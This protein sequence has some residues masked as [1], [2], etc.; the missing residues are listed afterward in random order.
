MNN[1]QFKIL[2]GNHIGACIDL[3][4]AQPY[5]AINDHNHDIYLP[6]TT[7]QKVSF[8]FTISNNKII[9]N[10]TSSDIYG[11]NGNH[12]NNKEYELPLFLESHNL[13]F[14]IYNTEQQINEWIIDTQNTL[15]NEA[16]NNEI[17]NNI[18][19]NTILQHM[20]TDNKNLSPSKFKNII[21]KTLLQIKRLFKKRQKLITLILLCIVVLIL[22][23]T[24]L[25]KY[26]NF[27]NK[28]QLEQVN[29]SNVS[30]SLKKQFLS[31]PSKYSGLKLLNNNNKY[32]LVGIVA[33]QQDIDFLK[34]HFAKYSS[35]IEFS[36][37]QSDIAIQKVSQILTNH[38]LKNIK[39]NFDTTTQQICLSG[40][41]N[42]LS[43]VNDIELDISNQILSLNNLDTSKVFQKTDIEKDLD[44]IIDSKLAPRLTVTKNWDLN[45]ISIN[46]FL[47]NEEAKQFNENI[48]DFTLNY[49]NVFKVNLD[50]KDALNI[51]PF[52]I[53]QVYTGN[54]Q[55]LVTSKGHKVFVGGEIAGFKIASIDQNKIIFSGKFPIIIPLDKITTNNNP[56]KNNT[57]VDLT[58]KAIDNLSRKEIIQNEKNQ[59]AEALNKE[60][61]YLAELIKLKEHTTDKQLMKFI[62]EH[63]DSLQLDIVAKEKELEFYNKTESN[64]NF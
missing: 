44:K 46:G 7:D 1:Y 15:G 9:I 2:N 57:P 37:L 47:T 62:N 48:K 58:H 42:S 54:P 53:S 28:L 55:F 33:N 51:L 50:I 14:V 5:I 29:N 45:I 23:I 36:I 38:Q 17:S 40:I 43:E 10:D 61:K 56:T 16:I 59:A 25:I 11:N 13:K 49:Q 12:I 35:Q 41:V 60:K 22:L 6:I 3:M 39:V 4:D 32:T 20:L 18:N 21:N 52:N 34:N 64:D 8:A 27:T 19:T 31:L 30:Q 63:V 24:G 26:S